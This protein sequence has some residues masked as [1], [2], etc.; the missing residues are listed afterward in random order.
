MT[1]P[2]PAPHISQ[3]PLRPSLED[4]QRPEGPPLRESQCF[5]IRTCL[6]PLQSPAGPFSL[7]ALSAWAVCSS[8]PPQ[9]P[10]GLTSQPC[11]LPKSPALPGLQLHVNCRPLLQEHLPDPQ[12]RS[13]PLAPIIPYP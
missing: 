10:L 6:G 3:P 13:G 12:T 7:L 11:T 8:P 1:C 9:R 4:S 5:P 2:P